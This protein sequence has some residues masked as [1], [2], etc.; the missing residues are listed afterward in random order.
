MA[1]Q[2]TDPARA[3]PNPVLDPTGASPIE[4]SAAPRGT[5]IGRSPVPAILASIL[6]GLGFAIFLILGPAS[7][8]S[9]ATVTGSVLAAFGLGWGLMGYA[10][11]R[12]SAQ[13]Q[14]WMRVPAVGL[15]LTGLALI[16][17][18]PGP[19]AIE[20]LSWIWPVALAAQVMWMVGQV[21][22]GVRGRGRWLLMP[23]LAVLIA[24]AIGGAAATVA[25]AF[26]RSDAPAAGRLVDVG[27]RSLYLECHGSGSPV[28]LLQAGLNGTAADWSQVASAVAPSTTVCV[29]DRAG[30]GWSDPAAGPQDGAA[31]AEDLRTLLD[32]AGVVGPYLL[33]GHS[34][35][36]PYMRVFADRYADEVAGMVLIDA[37]PADAFTALP[38]YP[39]FYGPYRAVTTLAP[40]LARAGLG[41]LLAS[42]ADP[43]GVRTA[44]EMRDEVLAL[45]DALAQAEELT[46]IGDRPLV[47]LTAGSGGQRG[48][49]AAQD[50]LVSLSSNVVHRV[51][52]NATHDSLLLAD[53]SASSQAILDVVAAARSG[54]VIR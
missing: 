24:F 42:P 25:A 32:R 29:Y 31:I 26:G 10:S 7:G 45:P 21:R 41:F 13:P 4:R 51:V 22:R 49:L 53:A 35:G 44:R 48:W 8:G 54:G 37:Q 36:G 1:S 12:F 5:A 9:E 11:T 43:S 27:G 16:I 28:A 23:V 52:A 18:Q 30:H 17:V 38:D 14:R 20:L 3:I 47:V 34:S 6:G 46:T 39:G 33:V 40:S 50:R 15:G 2:L 19:V